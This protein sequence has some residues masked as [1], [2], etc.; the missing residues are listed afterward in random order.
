MRVR[1]LFFGTLKDLT[2]HSSDELRLPEG[3]TLGDVLSHYKLQFPGLKQYVPSLALSLNQEYASPGASLHDDD[4]IGLLPPVSGG[5]SSTQA[6]SVECALVRER[7]D[8]AAIS[9][10]IKRGEDGAVV[11]FEGTVR[12]HTRGR[13]TLFLDYEAY[14]AMAL[15]QVRAL[16]GEARQKF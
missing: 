11:V 2:G 7:I 8:V 1:V 10:A 3:A 16:V 6:S 4:E 9:E 12:D 14:E 15:A 5:A 13:Q